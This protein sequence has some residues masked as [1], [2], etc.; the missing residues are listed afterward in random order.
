MRCFRCQ[1][2][3][4][5]KPHCNGRPVCCRCSSTEHTDEN[6]HAD[7]PWCA[8]CGEDQ[9]PHAAFD[10]TCPTF[11]KENEIMSI[12]AMRNVTY[13]EARDIYNATHPT[14][15]YAQKAKQAKPSVTQGNSFEQISA[16]QLID[17]LKSYGLSI[18]ASGPGPSETANSAA[19][20]APS[21]V[22][23]GVT[24]SS[25]AT[26]PGGGE[27]PTAPIM[28][29]AKTAATA[30]TSGEN[31]DW[32]LVQ[33]RR[34]AGR[35]PAPPSKPVSPGE[36][37]AG[38]RTS[39]PP[40]AKETAVQAALRRNEEQKRARD[41]RKARLVE[42]GREN[43]LSR[44]TGSSTDPVAEVAERSPIG[45]IA[46]SLG[47]T[48]GK[49]LTAP[50]L[51]K[52]PSPMGPPPAPPPTPSLSAG[53]G[54]DGRPLGTPRSAP[55]TLEPPPAPGRLGKRALAWNGSP[56]ERGTPRSRHKPHPPMENRGRANSAD[57]R[58]PNREVT[59][60]RVRLGDDAWS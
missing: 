10:R 5:T 14:V 37:A 11:I 36:R 9:K 57:G 7:T 39:D 26:R 4:H 52:N 42:R 15:S 8:N 27:P 17:L 16:A 56:S 31:D 35:R 50:P 34:T 60:P 1:K 47:S 20:V 51:S 18:V 19:P 28:A 53:S 22:P 6:C 46:P 21:S 54:G 40:P 58:L 48:P 38:T 3:G 33:D 59:H 49:P 24:P 43:R 25:P 55:R 30:G 13:R 23:R 29:P 41:A 45:A 44:A 2:F 32:T 12:K